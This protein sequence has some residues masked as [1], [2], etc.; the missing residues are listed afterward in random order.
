MPGVPEARIWATVRALAG[1]ARA[2]RVQ[3]WL[4]PEGAPEGATLV[5][6]PSSFPMIAPLGPGL[7]VRP[8]RAWLGSF[9]HF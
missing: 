3:G 5:A 1:K 2:T 7:H 4:G 8:R 6:R 9:L